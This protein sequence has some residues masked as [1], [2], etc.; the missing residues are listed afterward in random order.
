MSL[1]AEFHSTVI[2][3]NEARAMYRPS[4]LQA[5]GW[6]A[7]AQSS[8]TKLCDVQAPL[9]VFTSSLFELNNPSCFPAAMGK[10][11]TTVNSIS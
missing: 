9:E 10:C 3:N 5:Q 7:L 6:V 2:V 8:A 1:V 11:C 4:L